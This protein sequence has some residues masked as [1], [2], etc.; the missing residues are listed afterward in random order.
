MR[1]LT[2]IENG[3]QVLRWALLA[4]VGTNLVSIGFCWLYSAMFAARQN[5][6][7]YALQGK[8]PVMVALSQNVKDN[9]EAEAKAELEELHKLLFAVN[10]DYNEIKYN[11]KKALALADASVAK[12]YKALE[13]NG[14][15]RQ[16]VDA[17][18]R[19][20]YVLDSVKID[21]EHY[22]YAAVIYGKTGIVRTSSTTVRQLITTCE[23]RNVSRTEDIPHGFFIEHFEIRDNTDIPELQTIYK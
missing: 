6:K 21:F 5:E 10:P 19:T 12:Q 20:N 15:F 8:V 16:L 14:Y 1:L 13:D 3:F 11:A 22:P 9:R 2:N 18:I 17:R 4:I 7:I 23:L